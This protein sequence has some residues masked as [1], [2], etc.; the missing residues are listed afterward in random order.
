M[1]SVRAPDPPSGLT[2][3]LN[4][5]AFTVDEAFAN[6][7]PVAAV[8]RRSATPKGQERPSYN[9][10]GRQSYQHKRERRD[11]SGVGVGLLRRAPFGVH[12][13]VGPAA[14]VVEL[15]AEHPR[16]LHL[17]TCFAGVKRQEVVR[18]P[19]HG[20][21][22]RVGER[23]PRLAHE[24]EVRERPSPSEVVTVGLALGRGVAALDGCDRRASGEGCKRARQ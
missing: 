13:P 24:S 18:N 21:S 7:R 16:H 17:T 4:G 15:K 23:G 12:R 6:A 1:P 5:R 20:G 9:E 2:R 3:M 19:D 22:I 8:Q 11:G 10:D 14:A